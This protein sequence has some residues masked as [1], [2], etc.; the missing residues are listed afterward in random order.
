VVKAGYY[1]PAGIP[2]ILG[3]TNASFETPSVGTGYQ[4]NPAGG[5][6]TFSGQSGIQGNGSAWG[7]PTAPAGTQTAFLQSAT[8]LTNGSV[9]QKVSL[10]TPGSYSLLFDAALR[11]SP[12]NGAIS[13]NVLVNGTVVGTASPTTSNS[14]TSY[15]TS[16]FTI[17]TA[18][19][20]TVAFA[21][22]GADVDSSIFLDAVALAGL[23]NP[24]FETPN[25]GTGGFEY[26][27]NGAGTWTFS[28]NSGIQANGSAWGAPAAPAGTQT[29]FLQIT[30]GTDNGNMYETCF[31]TPGT[32]SVAF[33]AALR[34]S[35]NGSIS[36]NVVLDG[37][38]LG[39]YSPTTT[40]SFTAYTT[41]SFTTTTAA[42][43]TLQ[44]IA[45]GTT[46]VDATVFID[47]VSLQ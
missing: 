43:H 13:L 11:G 44:F 38:V 28:A 31:C 47:N 46:A 30:G 10:Y 35:N 37:T 8:G 25:V 33:D 23:A 24:S 40:S 22:V 2:P 1:R 21:A 29:A 18:G 20:N 19:T 26:N 34:A 45:V 41:S 12:H 15:V 27:P 39:T 5:G 7:A 36:F 32:Y 17:A 6:W 14:F 9:S 42:C 3:V 16:P 4:Y